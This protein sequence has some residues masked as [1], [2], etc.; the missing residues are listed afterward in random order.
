MQGIP[1][2]LLDEGV[3]QLVE[4]VIGAIIA[5]S[6]A[7]FT[8]A[9]ARRGAVF[10]TETSGDTR[11]SPEVFVVG[12]LC[13][14]IALGV[15]V[16]GLVDRATIR[17]QGEATAWASLTAAFTLGFA[18]MSV[19]AQHRWWWDETS[20]SWRGVFRR[21][22]ILWSDIRRAGKSW[23]GQF[24]ARD[25]RGHAIRWTTFTLHHQAI[26]KAADAAVQRAVARGKSAQ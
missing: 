21:T 2:W 25:R 19:Y 22:T 1:S 15:L 4:W 13:A 5:V 20:L 10:A 7:F 26:G 17:G 8:T 16:W 24:V 3:H 18:V 12:A 11:Q 6:T 23:D 9:L 14:V